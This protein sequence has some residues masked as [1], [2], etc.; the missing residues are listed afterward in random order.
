MPT[1]IGAN[2][3]TARPTQLVAD[4]TIAMEATA[5]CG[6]AIARFDASFENC[7]PT[8]TTTNFDGIDDALEQA[9]AAGVRY[10]WPD[11]GPYP[12]TTHASWT[13]LL[14][15]Y[16]S[17]DRLV[18]KRPPAGT[19]NA[20]WD[21]LAECVNTLLAYIDTKWQAL[22][23]DPTKVYFSLFQEWN[24]GDADGPS[25]DDLVTGGAGDAKSDFIA[26]VGEGTVDTDADWQSM[27]GINAGYANVRGVQNYAEYL[28]ALVDKPHGFTWVAPAV[29]NHSSTITRESNTYFGEGVNWWQYVV[30]AMGGAL[31]L[32]LHAYIGSQA[33]RYDIEPVATAWRVLK[34]F[35]EGRELMKSAEAANVG[36][37]RVVWHCSEFGILPTWL[38]GT[39]TPGQMWTQEKWGSFLA[40][41]CDVFRHYSGCATACFEE[42]YTDPS[43][44]TDGYGIINAAGY[45]SSAALAIAA[46]NGSPISIMSPP[47]PPWGGTWVT[48]TDVGVSLG[49]IGAWEMDE[50]TGTGDLIDSIGDNDLAAPDTHTSVAGFDGDA[51]VLGGALSVTTDDFNFITNPFSIAFWFKR[52]A[53]TDTLTL[54]YAE[55]IAGRVWAVEIAATTVAMIADENGSSPTA[56][57]TVTLSSDTWHFVCARFDATN[58]YLNVN[59]RTEVSAA[60]LTCGDAT[61]GTLTVTPTGTITMCKMKAAN[62]CWTDA[63][64]ALL[65]SNQAATAGVV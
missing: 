29:G 3:L 30:A 33:G 44:G 37:S 22:G 16:G 55:A 31:H 20:G 56:F 32:D 40:A 51:T 27:S 17:A 38:F 4:Q 12:N 19:A 43:L 18:K 65:A 58:I 8:T 35:R 41:A 63:Y 5:G 46:A 10:I 48:G 21:K 36:A 50:A 26:E 6:F 25:T 23:G 62:E 54:A 53:G 28:Y 13:A 61:G 2:T 1:L 39:A 34:R 60:A 15:T 59:A 11:I 57:D 42:I 64:V 47:T 7:F 45:S 24:V 9:W 49:L 14:G 52:S